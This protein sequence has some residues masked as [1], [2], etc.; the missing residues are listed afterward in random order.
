MAALAAGAG[1]TGALIGSF[2]NVV[3]HRLPRGESVVKPR[4]RCPGCGTE[5]AM[6][7]N[8]PILSWLLL[9]GRC[10]TCRTAIS[11]RYPLIEAITAVCFAAVAV[12]NG[13]NLDLVWELPFVAMLV[14]VGAIDLE[15]RIVPN[16]LLA[17]AAVAAVAVAVV[18]RLDAGVELAAAGAG[19]FL[20]MLVVALIQP[21]GMGMGDVKLAGVMGLYLGLAVVPALLLAFLS[22][23]LVG[24]AMIARAGAGERKRAVPFAPFLALGGIV[25]VMAGPEL[26]SLYA[27][28]F[29]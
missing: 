1:F 3:V 9:R 24:L 8:L 16:R 17:P 14:A 26:I 27:D 7:D 15:S 2:L 6:R 13:V 5:L 23:S 29:L 25:A 22:G 11:G 19:A 18:L 21:Q 10:R 28:R 4:S 12:A 20:F